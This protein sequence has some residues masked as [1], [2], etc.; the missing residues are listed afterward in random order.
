MIPRLAIPRSASTTPLFQAFIDYRMGQQ[1][2]T[3]FG[4]CQL[5]ID[6]FRLAKL[7]YDVS[8]DIIDGAGDGE[9]I[10][11]FIVRGDLYSRE[12]TEQLAHSY[13]RLAEAFASQPGARIG[14]PRMFSEVETEEALALG[15]G[16]YIPQV[17]CTRSPAS[18]TLHIP[19]VRFLYAGGHHRS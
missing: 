4:D 2:K 19:L 8:L 16:Q 5:E 10:L 6:S 14:E 3:T 17:F 15:R 11:S 12:D 9:S 13:V 7:T 1:E 18:N